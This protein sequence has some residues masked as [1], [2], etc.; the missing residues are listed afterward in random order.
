MLV[1][2]LHGA[3]AELGRISNGIVRQ[4]AASLNLPRAAVH[5]VVSCYHDFN[6]AASAHHVVKVCAAEAR[7][8]SPEL[9]ASTPRV[10]QNS[11]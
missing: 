3:Q 10:A 4:L 8:A 7:Q 5:G 6:S 2:T 9:V 1:Q 11:G